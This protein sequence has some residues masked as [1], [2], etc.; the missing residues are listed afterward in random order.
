MLDYT[1]GVLSKT[2]DDFKRITFFSTLSLQIF[3]IGYLIYALCA[4]TGIL[5]ANIILLTLSSAYLAFMLYIHWQE[6]EKETR[7]LLKNIYR[8]S[9]RAIKAFTLGVS[10]Y[11]LFIAASEPIT[12]ESLISVILVV[13]MLLAWILDILFSLIVMVVEKRKDLFL[14]AFKMDF[15]P[16]LKA[17]NFVNKI[18]GKE[19]EDE[20]VPTKSRGVLEKLSEKRK[21]KIKQQKADKKAEKAALKAAKKSNTPPTDNTPQKD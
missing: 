17:V 11:G 16:A 4:G 20:I 8:W 2:L 12:T 6:V 14:N 5:I 13:F 10:I 18:R 7:R 21:A 19:V 3:Q 15:E 1:K 9:K